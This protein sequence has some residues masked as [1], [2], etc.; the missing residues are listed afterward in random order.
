MHSVGGSMHSF[1]GC[2]SPSNGEGSSASSL[3]GSVHSV[4]SESRDCV[5][6]T[7]DRPRTTSMSAPG[8]SKQAW[9]QVCCYEKD[10]QTGNFLIDKP[11]VQVDGQ[12]LHPDAMKD[13]DLYRISLTGLLNEERQPKTDKLLNMIGHGILLARDKHTGDV[14]LTKL[15]RQQI[16]I[17][18]E[19][20]LAI[21]E[22]EKCKGRHI[23]MEVNTPYT[24]FNKQQ[25]VDSVR[26]NTMDLS[27]VGL[28]G[29]VAIAFIKEGNSVKGVP[30]WIK[31]QCLEAMNLLKNMLTGSTPQQLEWLR[32]QSPEPITPRRSSLARLSFG[33]KS[34]SKCSLKE[35]PSSSKYPD[36][37]PIPRSGSKSR[38]FR[39]SKKSLNSNSPEPSSQRSSG[40]SLNYDSIYDIITPGPPQL[41]PRSDILSSRRLSSPPDLRRNFTTADVSSPISRA[42]PL[43][44]L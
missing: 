32:K 3:A 23:K 43:P 13:P 1:D 15:C 16:F 21:K 12:M 40:V 27:K 20:F 39:S 33:S 9:L 34:S 18:N 31:I 25:F 14:T 38:L 26:N 29:Q 19:S 2:C 22:E 10:T 42:S 17:M 7:L 36:N 4:H 11:R 24:I 5:L 30:C 35:H 37:V 41:S 44:D 6:T 8:G 28:I